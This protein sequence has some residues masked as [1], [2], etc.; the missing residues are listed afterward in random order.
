MAGTSQTIAMTAVDAE[1]FLTLRGFEGTVAAIIL[2][3]GLL[4]VP[5]PLRLTADTV[6]SKVAPGVTLVDYHYRAPLVPRSEGV[7]ATL[8]WYTW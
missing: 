4:W 1:S 8:S 7:M 3:A 5:S 2:T 6:N